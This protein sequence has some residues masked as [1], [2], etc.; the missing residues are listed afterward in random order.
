MTATLPE[1]R[2]GITDP[3]PE[4]ASQ[5]D[6]EAPWALPWAA[7]GA[8]RYS[9][10]DPDTWFPAS[11][12]AEASELPKAIC[13]V[14]TVRQLCLA[15]A[16]QSSSTVGIWGGTDEAERKSMIRRAARRYKKEHD[17]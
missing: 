1:T 16:L 10:L 6:D 14:C 7:S 4:I 17:D 11:A 12:A 9:G 8:C 2:T 5:H 15:S 3:D 13:G